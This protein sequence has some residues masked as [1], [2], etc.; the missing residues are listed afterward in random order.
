M[1]LRILGMG[2]LSAQLVVTTQVAL[3]STIFSCVFCFFFVVC[4]CLTSCFLL[5]FFF[6]YYFGLHTH[7]HIMCFYLSGTGNLGC[8]ECAEG[9]F[10]AADRTFCGE[11]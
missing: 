1:I 4:V 7:K 9:T 3:V 10:S 6:T 8:T 2:V 11:A 5:F